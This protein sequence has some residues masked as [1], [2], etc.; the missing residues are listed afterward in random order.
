MVLE[1]SCGEVDAKTVKVTLRSCLHII[2]PH[3]LTCIQSV[4]ALTRSYAY[5]LH[6]AYSTCLLWSLSSY[7]KQ[8]PCIIAAVFPCVLPCC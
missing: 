3:L 6:I 8:V 5:R 1:A 2:I 4:Y 7:R